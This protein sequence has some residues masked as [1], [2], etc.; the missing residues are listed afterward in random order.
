MIK[1]QIGEEYRDQI[2]IRFALVPCIYFGTIVYHSPEKSPRQLG[3]DEKHIRDFLT[4]GSTKLVNLSS[5]K[6][7]D[8][9]THK[10]Y[11]G[12]IQ[13]WTDR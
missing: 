7:K 9:C 1:E 3:L 13:S 6:N 2:E 10:E 8:W 12:F 5:N 11:V 4:I